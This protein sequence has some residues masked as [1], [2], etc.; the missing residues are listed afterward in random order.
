LARGK[1]AYISKDDGALSG[2]KWDREITVG[3][4]LLLKKLRA[5]RLQEIVRER[6]RDASE[7]VQDERRR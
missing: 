2:C 5:L 4:D 1:T 7:C 3:S 6:D